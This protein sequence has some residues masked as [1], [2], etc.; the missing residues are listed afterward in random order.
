MQALSATAGDQIRLTTE[1]LIRENRKLRS[2]TKVGSDI[3]TH[4]DREYGIMMQVLQSKAWNPIC[5]KEMKKI[6]EQVHAVARLSCY[7]V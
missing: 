4:L 2:E 6:W 1:Q 5:F 3:G 7:G